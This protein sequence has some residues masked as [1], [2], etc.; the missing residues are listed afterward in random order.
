M[1]QGPSQDTPFAVRKEDTYI[2]F[3]MDVHIQKPVETI[4]K[5]LAI[6]FEFKHYKPKKK[7]VSTKCWSFIEKDEIKEG[8]C[9]IELYVKTFMLMLILYT[10]NHLSIA[11]TIR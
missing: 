6:F 11:G 1:N 9:I 3:D 2:Y 10:V 4:S 5:G 8:P 7:I